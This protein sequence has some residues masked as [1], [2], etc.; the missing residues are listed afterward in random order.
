MMKLTRKV[1]ALGIL[2]AVMSKVAAGNYIP[3]N[4]NL[5]SR[6]QFSDCR[7]GVFLHWGIY[8]MFAQGE[9]YLQSGPKQ[10]EYAKAA[11]A[12]YP[13]RFNA[14]SWVRAIKD[15]GARYICITSRHHDGF[16]MWGTK[17]SP[18]NIVDATPFGRDVLKELSE[19]CRQEGI[20]LHFYYSHLDWGRDD[21][22]MGR[23]GHEVGKDTTKAD[24]QH[25][26]KF[27]NAQLTELLTNYGP[28]GG[29]WFDGVW[30]HDNDAT[31]FDWHL[32]EQYALIHK[33]QPAC[34]VGN[35]HHKAVVPG[36]D[37]Q[38]FEKDLPGDNTAGWNKS[39]I[40][41]LP[42][43]TCETMNGIWGYKITDQN[44]KSAQD[45]IRML[46][47]ASGR[48][49]NLLMNL[50]PQ[51]NGELPALGLQRLHEV[52]QWMKKYGDTIYGTRGGDLAPQEWGVT[53]RKGNQL[54]V[55]VLNQSGTTISFPL[56]CKVK[57]AK[58]FID[59]TSVPFKQKNGTLTLTLPEKIEEVDCVIALTTKE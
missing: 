44:Y 7:F 37:F 55:H 1:L 2:L 51:P 58:L 38:M 39:E 13:H 34:L 4:E 20:R 48:N 17:Q 43:E 14:L 29:I 47:N 18:Y 26:F 36:E 41:A 32:E 27:M 24:F 42:L 33:L 21:Y 5:E 11:D 3:T 52:G 12:F 53:T 35:N 49:A 59:G 28:I 57:E 45:I 40:S 56:K 9:W 30:D 50:G 16:S 25:Y 15:A 19:A 46:V 31:P 8:S 6:K 10:Y 23:T 54:Y 22:P